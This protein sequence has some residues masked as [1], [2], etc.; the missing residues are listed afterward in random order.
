MWN[1]IIHILLS[2]Q[3]DCMKESWKLWGGMK[4]IHSMHKKNN[5][6]CPQGAFSLVRQR[7]ETFEIK[8][9]NCYNRWK[10]TMARELAFVL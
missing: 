4:L 9:G 2:G 6:L 5:S 10:Q 8:C 3:E 1:K 7:G